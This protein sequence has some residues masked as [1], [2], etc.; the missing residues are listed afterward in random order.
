MAAEPGRRDCRDER[1]GRSRPCQPGASPL[2]VLAGL[3]PRCSG[4]DLA[5]RH[6]RVPREGEFRPSAPGVVPPVCGIFALYSSPSRRYRLRRDTA[7]GAGPQTRRDSEV[8]MRGKTS[9]TLKT[10]FKMVAVNGTLLLLPSAAFAAPAHEPLSDGGA[11]L[12]DAVLDFAAI[13][14]CAVPDPAAKS[15]EPPGSGGGGQEGGPECE[16]EDGSP[17]ECTPSENLDQ[18]G[19]DAVDAVRQCN[20]AA[21]N[22]FDR[23]VCE[24]G[25]AGDV[26]ACWREYFA[27]LGL[28][29]PPFNS[30]G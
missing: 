3:Y 29:W 23:T 22:I 10:L 20:D 18:C 8:T 15:Q 25:Y 19:R 13:P 16:N 5:Y 6:V 17:R 26:A 28:P 24:F 1:S 12:P 27:E 14:G 9:H 11:L 7:M 21:R 30:E 4:I 2:S